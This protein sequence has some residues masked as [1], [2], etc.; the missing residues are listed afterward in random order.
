VNGDGKPDLVAAGINATSVLLGN[1]NG[2]VQPRIDYSAGYANFPPVTP[3]PVPSPLAVVDVN[4]DAKPDLVVL[5][6]TANT[7]S[8]LLNTGSGLFSAKKDFATGAGPQSIAVA[9]A[10]HDG[11]PDIIVANWTDNTVSVLPGNG[12]GTFQARANYPTGR[13]PQWVTATDING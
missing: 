8:G 7:V 2:T 12:D 3:F 6:W 11:R 13:S 9:D 1:G 10:N 5:N 4:R